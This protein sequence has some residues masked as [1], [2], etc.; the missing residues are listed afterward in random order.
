MR[1]HDARRVRRRCW[2][3]ASSLTCP[4]ARNRRRACVR[5]GWGVGGA[6]A[7]ESGKSTVLKQ[8]KILHQGGY[9]AEE[10]ES[11]REII[12][13]NAI[14]SMQVLVR[15]MGTINP[16]IAFNDPAAE[17]RG[18]PRPPC[19]APRWKAPHAG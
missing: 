11:Y 4:C 9:S 18:A 10:R 1:T 8:M 6:G 17:V 12:W 5:R 7:G 16:P 15:G 13:S 3:F 14:Q 2:R 19:P